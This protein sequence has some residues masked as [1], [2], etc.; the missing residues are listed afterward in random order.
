[1][2]GQPPETATFGILLAFV[3]ALIAAFLFPAE[4]QSQI[5]IKI[6][7]SELGSAGRGRFWTFLS[8]LIVVGLLWGFL[9]W[10][11]TAQ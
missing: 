10:L 7:G 11:P 3:I 9:N 8:V 6:L 2:V 5:W 4:A 1:M